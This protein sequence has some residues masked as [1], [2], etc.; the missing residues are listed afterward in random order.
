[1]KKLFLT[2]CMVLVAMSTSARYISEPSLQGEKA[3]GANLLYGTKIPNFGIGLRYQHFVID[4]V[5]VEGVFDYLIKN[6]EFS[7]WDIN[8][9]VQ[10]VWN[11]GSSFRIYPLAGVCFAS[12]KNHLV[13]D[14]DPRVGLNVGAGLQVKVAENLWVGA[15]AKMQEMRHYHQGVFYLYASYCF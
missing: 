15:E 9:N 7:M 2:F 14:T 4:H 8:A 6:E 5:R 11:I 13:D 3:I 1:M 10:Y 12:W